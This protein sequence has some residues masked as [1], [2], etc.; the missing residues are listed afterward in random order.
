MDG[1]LF[2]FIPKDIKSDNSVVESIKYL[3]IAGKNSLPL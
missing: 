1:Y 3:L 2:P